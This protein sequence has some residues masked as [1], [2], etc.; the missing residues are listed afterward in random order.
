[1]KL[2]RR[3]CPV[4]RSNDDSQIVAEPDFDESQLGEL[5]FASR[6]TPEF[7]HFRMLRCPTCD[8]LYAN[9]APD[10]EWLRERY[11]EAG[12][13]AG[14]ESRYAARTYARELASIADELPDRQG[15]LDIGAGDGA[16]LEQLVAAGF[17][18]VS[19]I[20][21]SRAP[22]AAARPAARE[23]LREGFFASDLIPANSL[24]L[25]TCFQTLEH[26]EDPA[27]LCATAFD[28]LKPGG[29]L[30]TVAHNH[31]SISARILGR[32]SPIFDVEHLQLHSPRSLR[33]MLEDAGFERVRVKPLRNDYP[34]AYWIK[35][36][37]L[38]PAAKQSLARGLARLGL[39]GFAVP[40]WAGNLMAVGYKPRD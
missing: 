6:K 32:R 11:R 27:G 40:L 10:L 29:A 23:L 37:P 18:D 33:F 36:L 20:E 17:R 39:A 14:E 4:C 3:S 30:F 5:S 12:F 31:R 34:V 9:P 1:M 8:L 28:A 19:G 21:P 16:F 35:L 24:C 15:A 22:I 7:M 2:V 38:A 13:D 26:S 25:V